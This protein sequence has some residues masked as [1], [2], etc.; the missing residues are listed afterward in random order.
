MLKKRTLL[1]VLAA[2]LLTTLACQ[3]TPSNNSNAELTL[4]ALYVEQTVEAIN[5][6]NEQTNSETQVAL[7]V[8]GTILAQGQI[9][10]TPTLLEEEP[11][12]ESA[13]STTAPSHTPS[14]TPTIA[15]LIRPSEP[16]WIHQWWQDTN[17]K[18]YASQ[19]RAIGGEKY[20][21]NQFERPYTS[22]EMLYH[23]DVDLV[24]VEISYDKTFYYVSIYLS[25]LNQTSNNLDGWY[26]VEFDTDID[27]RG[28]YLLWAHATDN[29]QWIT[30]EVYLYSDANNDV[31]GTQ[32]LQENA[33]NYSG[34]SYETIL[35]SPES[36]TDPDAAWVRRH[37]T[38][39]TAVQLAVKD[40]AIG[41]PV[42]FLWNGWADNGFADP[43]N[44][45]YNDFYANSQ[46][47]SP[48]TN[49]V[50]YP[51]KDLELVDN[52]C[53]LPFGF[54]PSGLEP[55]ICWQPTPTPTPVPYTSTPQPTLPPPPS[56]D[57][58]DPYTIT[59]QNCCESCG[60]WWYAQEGGACY[61]PI[62]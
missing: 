54:E 44:F 46:A 5:A 3:F 31:G 32:P 26:G 16:G 52:T 36:Y 34:D 4:E 25:G 50:Y 43:Q 19:K 17:T 58:S 35:F 20:F 28:D 9:Q 30:D 15:H 27:G 62:T 33:P 14:V 12:E 47:G 7:N 11:T 61:Y 60:Y 38:N 57:C 40:T 48:Y 41:S 49:S 45:D 55:G 1:F 18:P 24:K 2:L 59:D 21:L 10:A 42:T 56:C 23:P 39:A 51:V 8:Q 53:R 29:N 13:T 22:Q 6:Q 37:P